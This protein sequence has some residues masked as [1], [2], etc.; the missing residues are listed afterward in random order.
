[1][2]FIIYRVED[3][4]KYIPISMIEE[5]EYC[6]NESDLAIYLK[7]PSSFV[8]IGRTQEELS[9]LTLVVIPFEEQEFVLAQL[10]KLAGFTAEQIAHI[11]DGENTY[12]PS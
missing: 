5:I 10:H 3:L 9:K 1:M 11:T 6:F 12:E 4:T 7:E 8:K 2:M